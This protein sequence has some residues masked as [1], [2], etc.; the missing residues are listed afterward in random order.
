M[1]ASALCA[2]AQET[3]VT[4]WEN[5]ES[6]VNAVV[7]TPASGDALANYNK[8]VG[9]EEGQAALAG[10]D[11][12]R[13][14]YTGAVA[15]TVI[16]VQN[17]S[18]QNIAEIGVY[19]PK[20]SEGDGSIEFYVNDAAREAIVANGLYVRFNNSTHITRIEVLKYDKDAAGTPAPT[21]TITWQGTLEGASAFVDYRYAPAK[22]YLL[23]ALAP[24]KKIKVYMSGVEE[25]NAIY[26][27]VYGTGTNLNNET[28]LE[29]GATA[30]ELE[31]TQDDIDKIQGNKPGEGILIKHSGAGLITHYVTVPAETGGDDPTTGLENV[32][33]GDGLGEVR[34]YNVYGQRVSPTAK[35]LVIINGKKIYNR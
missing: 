8:L 33:V 3:A 9:T 20:I 1:A 34:A 26:F 10:G 31:V 6:T 24:G 5:V 32:A 25:G 30:Y 21:E 35:G 29:A 7:L 23:E 11:K 4:V 14:S 16:Y 19:A 27:Q 18:S 13:I 12:V 15:G 22:T 17:R 2:N 28:A